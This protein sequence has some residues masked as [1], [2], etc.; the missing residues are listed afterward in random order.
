M[1]RRIPIVLFVFNVLIMKNIQLRAISGAV[2]VALIVAGIMCG[3]WP[4][5]ALTA[6]FLVVGMSEYINLTAATVG[7]RPS[8]AMA[9]ADY[10]GSLSLWALPVGFYA[11]ESRIVGAAMA[12]FLFWIVVRLVQS[13]MSTSP[14]ALRFLSRSMLGL[15][16]LAVPMMLVNYVYIMDS[17]VDG[18]TMLMITFVCI[19][20][21]DTGVYLVGSKFGRRRLCERLSPKKS[22]E[23]FWGGLALV[24]LALIV[25]AVCSTSV[26][27]VVI[28]AIYGVVVSVLAT[29]GDL[30]GSLLKRTAGVK[31]SG[32]IIPGHGGVLDRI[33]S[34]LFAQYAILVYAGCSLLL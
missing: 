13:V 19:W 7:S 15:F 8:P 32:R 6:L 27:D 12:L 16:Y 22:W 9:V 33:D 10:V 29:V 25:Y 23:G 28:Y 14:D 34:F 26:S 11:A 31:D 20:I 18:P 4:F 17:A 24:V 30:F 21:N 3:A 2:Y 1:K 5:F